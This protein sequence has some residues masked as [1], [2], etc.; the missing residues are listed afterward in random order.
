[1][2]T[3]FEISTEFRISMKKLRK[4]HKRGLLRCEDSGDPI[5]DNIR[6]FLGSGQHLSVTQLV[7]LIEKPALMLEIGPN[8]DRAQAFLEAIG[9][10]VEPAPDDLWPELAGALTS[11]LGSLLRLIAWAKRAIPAGQQVS[12]HYL[13][14]R[15]LLAVPE[16]L[17]KYEAPRLGKIF[18]NMRKRGEFAGWWHVEKQGARSVTWYHQPK[19]LDL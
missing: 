2:T 5:A 15:L 6:Y 13:A 8:Q 4:M 11:D 12:H 16:H 9:S 10:P 19:N 17:R 14:V 1:M 7:A 3:L 18:L